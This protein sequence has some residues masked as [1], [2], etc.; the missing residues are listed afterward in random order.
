M[1]LD[2]GKM[3]TTLAGLILD[4]ASFRMA[5]EN[6]ETELILDKLGMTGL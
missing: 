2:S 3:I 1:V 5:E 4:F 6:E